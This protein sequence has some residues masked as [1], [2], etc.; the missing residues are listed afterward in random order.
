MGTHCT[1]PSTFLLLFV[2]GFFRMEALGDEASTKLY[3]VCLEERQHE[4][5]E[6]VTASHHEMLSSVL[7]SKDAAF[8]SIVY[9]YRYGFS[10]FAARLKESQA[11]QI[12][13][14]PEVLSIEPSRAFRLQTT[15]SW[16]YLGLGYQH[17]QPP[18]LLEK[19]KEGDGIIIGVVDTGIWPESRSFNDDGYGPVPSR[20]KGKCEV[21]QNF[22]VN[23][24]NRKIIG[25]RYYSKDARPSDVAQDYDSPR[26]ANGH[27]T[28]TASTAAGSL[29]SD[30]NFHGLGGG[31]ARGGAPRARLAIYKVCWVSGR[32]GKADVLQAIDDAVGDGVDIL[33]L[34]IGGHGYFPASLGAVKKGTTVVF[35]G[36]NDG[37]VPQTINNAV[38]WVITVAASTIDRSFPTDIILGNRR[39]LVGQSMCYA[40]SD[41]GYKVLVAFDSCSVVP[42][43]LTQLADKIV[44]CF[45]R[46][47]SGSEA[48]AGETSRLLGKLSQAGARGAIIARFPRSIPPDCSGITCVLVDYD[49]GGQ[50][51][52]YA[53][54]ETASGRIPLVHVNP[55]SNIVGS[56]VMSPRVAAFS[57]RGPSTGYPDLVKPDI[58]APG[59]NILAAVRD[60]YQFM[61][62]TSMACSH[63]SG[64]A[65]L[66]K[67]VHPDWSP[68]AIKSALVTTAYT[69]NER[70]FPVEAEAIPR[71]LADPFDFGGG[72]IDPNR[73]MD[74]GLIYDIHPN[75][76]V[77]FFRYTNRASNSTSG[78]NHLKLPSGAIPDLRKSGVGSSR[79]YDLNLPSISIPDLRET[80]VKV[81]R[82]VTNVGD[83][84]GRYMAV[85]QTP[86][87][88]K[89][90][91]Q[92]SVLHFRASGEKLNFEVTFTP[93]HNVQGGFTF[94]SLTWVHRRGKNSQRF[95]STA[96]CKMGYQ[97][98]LSS[99]LLL[100]FLSSFIQMAALGRTPS[101]TK[102]LYIVYMGE[103][104][105]E[106]PDLVTASHH[107]MLSSV[108]GSKEEAVSSIVYSYKHGF[109]GFAAMLTESQAHQ[110]AE[111]PEVISVN[112]SRSVPLLTTRSWDYLD[113]GFEQPQPTGLLA[114][115]NFGDGIII[116]VVDTGIWPESRSFDDHGYGPV[117]S[118]W[119]GTCEVGQN[120]T[121][122]HCNRKII[123]ARWY[124][125]G[126]DPS[127]IE[128]GYQSPRDSEGHGTHTASTA[129]G[130]LVSDA[131]F[132]GL[133]AGTARGGAPRARLAIYKACWAKA[134]CPDA[135]VLK[136]IDDA[137]HD[138]VD[139]LSL[140][141]GGVLHPYFASIHAVAKGITVIFAGGN[142]GPVTQTI[143]NDMPWVITV[144]ASTIDRSFPT[145]LTLGDNQTVVGQ[146]LL[147]ESMDE[148]FTKLAYG[149][150][151]SRDA[152]NS[153]DVVGK[154]VLCYELAIASSTPP[155]RH[156][157]L[158]AI[159]VQEAGGKGII[160]AQYS[161][162]ILHYI[163]E[164]CNGTVCV[165]VDYEMATLMS[166]Y[167]ESTR[168]PLV[169]VS[170]TQDMAGSGVMSPR[171]AAFSSR[172]PSILFPDLV[173]PDITAPGF[174]ILAAVKD[175]YKFDSGTS[176]ACPHVSG[177][178]AL[179]K[180]AHPQWS[181]AAIKSALVTTA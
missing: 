53:R 44:L 105:H 42:Q 45:D 135:A 120:F 126:V 103:R 9:S 49:V 69:T 122:N 179:L 165:F 114:R 163:D 158:A 168:S 61:P 174:L 55:A 130:S 71:K 133:G 68:A 93:L 38:P 21:G 56:Q 170:P 177:V 166:I 35:S 161:A 132:H 13:A 101:S 66:L 116:G 89:M 125:G 52:N 78:Q 102:L 34:S 100:L 70:G 142:D 98:L 82:T 39:T 162:S 19:G 20:W 73:A 140:S 76:Y 159:N 154:I 79:T 16:D 46:T 113:L 92:P 60:G 172:G 27:G 148:G 50:I 129:A 106:D 99:M 30:A 90:E 6:L 22:T 77:N 85:V 127:L 147:Y 3:I 167:A 160:F 81:I 141:L 31:T 155:K 149:G 139:I 72:H 26:D 12:A 57:G 152:L 109:S 63:V 62:G 117:P 143:A 121:V 8:N 128:G 75:D 115:G 15:R 151:C 171:V 14:L 7:G 23:H 108:L 173:K 137:I 58:T 157:P 17:H 74:P 123:G 178:V 176:M 64:I 29:V 11:D 51:A 95:S 32:C 118:R 1:P 164:I 111:M 156:F 2:L 104:Q 59:V 146:S 10:G 18:G 169:K 40:S 37:P 107:H 36:G 96:T 124:A 67:V 54:V 138:G 83:T 153:S 4:G 43:Y 28:H 91:V 181:P 136:A 134:G 33:S 25:A 119:K 180:A 87:G 144:A 97:H 145:L 131:S 175:S 150:S 88:V 80:P 86:A 94:G 84:H 24:C 5:P 41:P 110:I 65:A 48:A 112:P 47:F